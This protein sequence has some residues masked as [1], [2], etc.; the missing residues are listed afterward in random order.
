MLQR[1]PEFLPPQAR[2]EWADPW[3]IATAQ[4]S[5]SI[6][7][8]GEKFKGNGRDERPRIPDVCRGFNVPCLNT[9]EEPTPGLYFM[10]EKEGW[11]F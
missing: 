7:V 10:M 9:D 1:Y 8:T 6:V 4:R 11:T 3:V 2:R 5:G